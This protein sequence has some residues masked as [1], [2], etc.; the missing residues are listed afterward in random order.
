MPGISFTSLLLATLVFALMIHQP[1]HDTLLFGILINCFTP[2][3]TAAAGV[4]SLRLWPELDGKIPR[5]ADHPIHP[6]AT[7]LVRAGKPGDLG[8]L[9]RLV[10]AME[11]RTTSENLK[12]LSISV[13]QAFRGIDSPDREFTFD[14]FKNRVTGFDESQIF[15]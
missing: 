1:S 2:D 4:G 10:A 12:H 7:G 15:L 6:A 8:W 5:H 14:A 3:S 13:F 11:V 9:Y